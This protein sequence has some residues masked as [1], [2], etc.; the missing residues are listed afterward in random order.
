M[1]SYY[2][3]HRDLCT[4]GV[5]RQLIYYRIGRHHRADRRVEP[6]RMQGFFDKGLGVLALFMPRDETD[7][8]LD[9]VL[10]GL[11]L[12]GLSGAESGVPSLRR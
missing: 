6:A 4:E 8:D 9:D 3:R 5:G 2:T 1:L 7:N 12:P 11:D 10:D